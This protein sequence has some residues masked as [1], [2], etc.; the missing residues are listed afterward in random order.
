MR[1]GGRVFQVRMARNSVKRSLQGGDNVTE[2]V[3]CQILGVPRSVP[4]FL[5]V[6]RDSLSRPLYH[7]PQP[8]LT[9][10]T[11]PPAPAA[12]CPGIEAHL[13]NNSQ[14]HTRPDPT[15]PSPGSVKEGP[16]LT[17]PPLGQVT[18]PHHHSH[19][20]LP[21]VGLPLSFTP[22]SVAAFTGCRNTVL[23]LTSR[24]EWFMW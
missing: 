21:R 19:S 6:D 15:R 16:T 20:T 14:V 24:A 7:Q 18:Q 12:V 3:R 5:A 9:A 10:A 17:R 4:P 2:S 8:C 1:R 13:P 11:A 23:A 22:R